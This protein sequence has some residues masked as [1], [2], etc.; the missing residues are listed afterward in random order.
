MT[1][2]S[3]NFFGVGTSIAPRVEIQDNCIVA[4]CS[5]VNRDIVSKTRVKGIPARPY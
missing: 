5:F 4:A 3:L 2:G 1:I